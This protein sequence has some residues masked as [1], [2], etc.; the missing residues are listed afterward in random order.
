MQP[1]RL[2]RE[3]HHL[4]IEVQRDR[5]IAFQPRLEPDVAIRRCR[6][7]QTREVPL[8]TVGRK[9]PH[10][11]YV[12]ER[13]ASRRQGPPDLAPI[14]EPGNVEGVHLRWSITVWQR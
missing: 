12:L 11:R 2:R 5:V 6:P 4:R 9:L 7:I 13:R 8:S 3:R 10:R 14:G 1:E